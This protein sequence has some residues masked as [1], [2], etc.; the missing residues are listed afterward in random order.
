[1][2]RRTIPGL[3]TLILAI[4][5]S[6]G[7]TGAQNQKPSRAAS[8]EQP[9]ASASPAGNEAT[10]VRSNAAQA[11]ALPL[12]VLG[13]GTAGTITKWIGPFGGNS[14]TVGDSIINESANGNIGIGNTNPA[15]RLTVDGMIETRTGGLKFPDGSVQTTA[16]KS[17]S[18]FH[19][20][21]LTGNGSQTSPIGIAPRGVSTANLADSIVTGNKIASG[22]V[23]RS[24]NGLTDNVTLAAC[25]NITLTSAGSTLTIS[26]Q[27]GPVAPASTPVQFFLDNG[28]PTF[29]VP[30]GKRLVIEF[31]SGDFGASAT[32]EQTEV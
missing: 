21:S 13:G 25:P 15:S 8:G 20:S 4:T 11:A 2:K 10:P 22:V 23:V 14:I 26:A 18:L 32:T 31:V 24:V 16:V 7:I 17:F 27:T 28:N 30:A 29:Q 3:L 19:D 1:M 5:L 9:A 12:P 6:V